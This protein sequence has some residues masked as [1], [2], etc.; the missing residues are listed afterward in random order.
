[1]TRNDSI[2]MWTLLAVFFAGALLVF[3]GLPIVGAVL[4]AV[5][6]VAV[7]RMDR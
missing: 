3:A 7:W 2:A 1:M 5:V 4:C 6:L